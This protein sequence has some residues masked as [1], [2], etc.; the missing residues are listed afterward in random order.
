MAPFDAAFAE[1]VNPNLEGGFSN[2][3]SDNGNWTGGARGVGTLKGTKWGVSAAAFP[4]LDIANL[5]IVQARSI[6]L[7]WWNELQCPAVPAPLAS[8]LFKIAVNEG[9]HEAILLL[10]A[11]LEVAEDGVIGPQTISKANTIETSYA[12]SM[13]VAQSLMRYTRL[14]GF[15][16]DGVGWFRRG[17]LTAYQAGRLT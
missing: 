17:A 8:A 11:A 5:T 15:Q 12:V 3:P 6:Y 13:L 1:L 16:A 4:D 14:K 9:R 2:D 7:G 10:Q